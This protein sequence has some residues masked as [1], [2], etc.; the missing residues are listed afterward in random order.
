MI[1][2][3]YQIYI[4]LK[5]NCQE[6][7]PSTVYMNKKEAEGKANSLP[8]TSHIFEITVIDSYD[9]IDNALDSIERKHPDY[10]ATLSSALEEVIEDVNNPTTVKESE[11][12]NSDG[13][14]KSDKV[15]EW[16]HSLAN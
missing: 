8:Y 9:A 4:E 14:I 6:Y 13:S 3:G 16:L 15:S 2:T 5:G 12:H 7:R 1:R 10:Q 11:F